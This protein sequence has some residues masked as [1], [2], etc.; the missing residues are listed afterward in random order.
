MNKLRTFLS[1]ISILLIANGLVARS[2]QFRVEV[3]SDGDKADVI[4]SVLD[5]ERKTQA[6]VPDFS[7]I[8]EVSSANIEFIDPA[9][10]AKHGFTLVAASQLR[11]AKRDHVV[12][13]L[14]IKKVLLR[15]GVPI[16][17]LSRVTEGRPC[18]S[19]SFSRERTY[20]Y[21]SL[22]TSEGWLAR[23]I[24]KPA[25]SYFFAAKRLRAKG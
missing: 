15:D 21:E 5:L 6:S 13:Y 7:N 3:L 14:T 18:F 25:P 23:L 24:E 11:E 12:E 10:L 20:T 19:E 17:I 1:A 8:R 4:E 2:Q 22:R 16:V 9:R